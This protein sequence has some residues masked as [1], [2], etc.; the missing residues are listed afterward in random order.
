ML[1]IRVISF[2]LLAACGALCQQGQEKRAWS[3]LPDAPSVQA[4]AQAVTFR[5]FVDEAHWRLTRAAVSVNGRATRQSELANITRAARPGFPLPY[6]VE[7]IQTRAGDFFGKYLYPSLLKRSLNYHPSSSSSLM[8]RTA[9]AASRIFVVR[10]ASGKGRLNTSYFLGALASAAVHTA[11]RPYWRR[12]VSEP[13]SDFGST[14]GNDTGMN[15][16]HEFGPGLQQLMRS[17]APKFVSR[18]EERLGATAR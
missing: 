8:G 6:S 9:Y 3:S 16:F 7:P 17:H 18:I 1:P 11:H 10:D 5:T 15:L 12:S 4:S 14:I 2:L 13:F